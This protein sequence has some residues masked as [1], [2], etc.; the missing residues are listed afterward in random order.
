MARGSKAHLFQ[1]G[2]RASPGP[3]GKF[4]RFVTQR[5]IAMLHEEVT[6][7]EPDANAAVPKD[8]AKRKMI[9][10]RTERLALMCEALYNLALEG[11]LQAIKYIIDRI[12]GTPTQTTVMV[13]DFDPE[14]M[15]AERQRL[16]EARANLSK[17]TDA[18][19]TSLYFQ[20]LKQ[21]TGTSGSAQSL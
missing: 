16:T 5:L 15:E 3:R 2:N 17:L 10:R 11:D 6:V 13:E 18:E 21:V 8:P 9:A 4:G 7:L 12:E 14:K 1:P 20:T 19:R